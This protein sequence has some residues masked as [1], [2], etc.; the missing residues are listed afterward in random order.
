VTL[1][2]RPIWHADEDDEQ[3]SVLALARPRRGWW[4][5]EHTG[6]GVPGDVEFLSRVVQVVDPTRPA[7]VLH[8]MIAV[9]V[10]VGDDA[11]LPEAIER[12]LGIVHSGDELEESTEVGTP[13]AALLLNAVRHLQSGLHLTQDGVCEYIGISRSTVM[14]WKRS[15][16][17]HPRHPRIPLLLHLWAAVSGAREEFGDERT[18]QLVHQHGPGTERDQGPE[19]LAELLLDSVEEASVR[20]L[21]DAEYSADL[22]QDLTVE[23]IEAREGELSDALTRAAERPPG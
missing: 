18:V 10:V 11:I 9:Y 1:L 5:G 6:S 15:P 7:K 21:R 8:P 2:S 17:I 20:A 23:E 22:A 16:A 14:A 3:D 4:Q 12:L 19:A 13:N